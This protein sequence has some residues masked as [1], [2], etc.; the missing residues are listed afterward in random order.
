MLQLGEEQN[1]YHYHDIKPGR[2]R[3]YDG[4]D[5]ISD[6]CNDNGSDSEYMEL[7]LLDVVVQTKQ[8]TQ[9]ST[10][11]HEQTIFHR[12]ENIKQIPQ[13]AYESERAVCTEQRRF[14]FTLQAD[15]PL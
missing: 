5:T 10:T 1:S 4:S 13:N 15:F 9:Y 11:A 8:Q 14:P 12:V 3:V 6:E 2:L 7:G